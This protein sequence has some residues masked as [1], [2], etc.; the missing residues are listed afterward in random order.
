MSDLWLHSGSVST[1]HTLFDLV[2]SD[3]VR[4]LVHVP[5]AN[6]SSVRSGTP[7]TINVD[8]YPNETFAG[9]IARDA[10]AFDPTSRTLVLEI[11]VSNPYGRLFA[12][13][14]AHTRFSLPGPTAALLI[15]DN[16]ILIDSKGPHI[17]VVDS[18]NKIYIKSVEL[19]RDY[20]TKREVLRGLDTQDQV[21]QNPA[22]DLNEKMPVSI[23]STTQGAQDKSA[24]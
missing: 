24:S 21:V 23:Q 13:M 14:H 18:S 3:P 1:V 17:V 7:A 15:P 4:V 10:R 12:G 5:Q 16:A 2:Q 6:I 8:Q 19:G 11:D 9:K 20:G 22:D